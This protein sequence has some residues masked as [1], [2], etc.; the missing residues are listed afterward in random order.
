MDS[1]RYFYL[2][3]FFCSSFFGSLRGIEVLN[4]AGCKVKIIKI[5][6][7]KDPDEFLKNNGTDAF[8]NLINNAKPIVEYRINMAKSGK[9]LKDVEQRNDFAKEI[10]E[11][12]SKLDKS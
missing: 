9:N 4:N 8:K 11:I 5:P 6:L 2:L 12:L 10:V 3:L 1:A 7:G